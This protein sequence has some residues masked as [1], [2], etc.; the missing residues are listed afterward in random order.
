MRKLI[1]I[2]ITLVTC[3]ILVCLLWIPESTSSEHEEENQHHTTIQFSEEQ[4]QQHSIEMRT[5]GKGMLQTII[6]APAQL[7]INPNQEAHILPSVSGV[8]RVVRKNL[9]ETVAA[10]ELLAILD[11]REMADAKAAYLTALKNT[12]LASSTYAREKALYE[13]N[14][15]SA[16]EYTTAENTWDAAKIERDLAAQKLGTLEVTKDQLADLEKDPSLPLQRYELRAPINGKITAR[17]ITTGEFIDEHQ[18]VYVIAD[19]ST[20]WAE[21]YIFPQDRPYVAEGQNVTITTRQGQSAEAHIVYLSPTIDPDT[22]TSTAIAEL[23]NSSSTWIPGAFA[24]AELVA[25]ES[26]VALAVPREAVQNI[27]GQDSIF[28]AT[29]DGFEARPVTT[30]QCDDHHYEIIGG[31]APGEEYACKNTFLLKAELQKDEAEH[32]D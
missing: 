10:G 11:S 22:H 32:M 21:I 30:G 8:A 24:Q 26:P 3:A 23:N 6:R 1:T 4:K 12:Q 2:T 19:L 14:I 29:E 25:K 7:V 27:E 17:H 16:L 20:V 31:L 15:S 9:G 18:E 5:A 13:Q 28:V